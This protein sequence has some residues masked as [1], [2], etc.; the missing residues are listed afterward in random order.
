MC[1]PTE[2]AGPVSV[3]INPIFSGSSAAAVTANMNGNTVAVTIYLFN[4][5]S[6]LPALR[7]AR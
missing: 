1:L 7:P 6:I 3:V 2:A 5:I 4:L